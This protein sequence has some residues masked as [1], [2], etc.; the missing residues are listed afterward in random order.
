MKQA[1]GEEAATHLLG[2]VSHAAGRI[3]AI[4]FP[5]SKDRP[6]GRC[7]AIFPDRL[8]RSSVLKIADET[9]LVRERLP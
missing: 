3:E 2:R 9:G 6:D 1:Q 7:L 5:S 4:L 8:K